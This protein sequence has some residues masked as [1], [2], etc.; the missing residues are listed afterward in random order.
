MR[1]RYSTRHDIQLLPKSLR[2]VTVLWR[3]DHSIKCDVVNFCAHGMK[4]NISPSLPQTAL[5]KKNDVVKVQLPI[6]DVLFTGMCVYVENDIGDAISMGIYY[7]VPIEQN[8][9][10]KLL[11]K[12]LNVPLQETSFVSYEWE[13]FVDKLCNSEDP[14]LKNIGLHEKEIL[15]A[16]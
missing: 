7:Y 10:N 11:S 16:Q 1:E 12:S 4:V 15:V 9:F 5:P 13:E 3:L 2:K 6:I 8:Y 14:K